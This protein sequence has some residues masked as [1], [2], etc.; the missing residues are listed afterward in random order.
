MTRI[1]NKLEN[2]VAEFLGVEDAIC[3][4]MGFA[5]NSMNTPSLMDKVFFNLLRGDYKLKKFLYKRLKSQI[6]ILIFLNLLVCLKQVF[7]SL[8]KLRFPLRKIF[9][10]LMLQKIYSQKDYLYF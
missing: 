8:I 7:F 3:F 2:L 10:C 6:F 4:S 5:T 9:I 1:Q